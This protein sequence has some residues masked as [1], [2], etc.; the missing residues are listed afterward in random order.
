MSY[1]VDTHCH[2][3]L[4]PG[5]RTGVAE[6]DALPIKTITVTNTPTLWQPNKKIFKEC[7]NIR[8]ALG[9]HPELASRRAPE[10]E[11]LRAV[12]A[13]AKYIGEIGLDG[14]SNEQA[15]RHAQLT[16]FRNI[17]DSLKQQEP[18]I[19]TVH[20]RGAARETIEE[21]KQA[22]RGTS[23]QVILHWFSGGLDELRQA[24]AAGFLFSVNH[25]MVTSRN[26]QQ[27][28]Q[29]LPRNTV[30]TETDAPFTFAGNISTRQHSLK[31]TLSGLAQHWHC[32]VEEAKQHV[33]ECFGQMVRA[34]R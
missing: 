34:A 24:V 19:L 5:I 8:V 15:E 25:K 32:E 10:V 17:L 7:Y 33:W 31:R 28:I 30:L 12:F 18:K 20:S 13:E 21:L 22:V 1:Y 27:I 11:K 29:A 4:F 14:T 3:D 23:H 9:L 16:V 2:L 6:E 26:G